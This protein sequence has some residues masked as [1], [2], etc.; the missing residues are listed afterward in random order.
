VTEWEGTAV[1]PIELQL[2]CSAGELARIHPL[3]L[4]RV[5]SL[6]D[7]QSRRRSSVVRI[8]LQRHGSETISGTAIEGKIALYARGVLA[9]M[10][11]NE[12][13]SG[14]ATCP[15]VCEERVEGTHILHS[16]TS[17]PSSVRQ[18]TEQYCLRAHKSRDDFL[19]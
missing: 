15:E 6:A 13:T 10:R 8:S 16:D 2:Q 7:G 18:S 11:R 3:A 5:H 14:D 4:H 12:M 1:C 19:R 9:G 17:T